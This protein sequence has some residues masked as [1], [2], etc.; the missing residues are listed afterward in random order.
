MTRK[1]ALHKALEVL[2][3]SGEFEAITKIHEIIEE[4]PLT[5]WGERTIFDTIDQFVIDNGRNPT[6]TDFIPKGM[7]PHP[8]IKLRFGITLGEFLA[9]YYPQPVI[10]REKQKRLFIS[11]YE[12]IMP[13]GACDFNKK[14]ADGV[15]TWG[16]F[17]KMF[18]FSRWLEWVEFCELERSSPTLRVRERGKELSVTG[19]V[20][21]I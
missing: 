19:Y 9:T 20:D 7:P 14:R 2:Q 4:L 11:E 21:L 10:D 5:G 15:P 13:R 3:E 18:G 1:Q 17:A 16:T 12:R 6:A 8:V